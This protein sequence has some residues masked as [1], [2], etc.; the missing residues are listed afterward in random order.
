MELKYTIYTYIY[1]GKFIFLRDVIIA[2]HLSIKRKQ[3]TETIYSVSTHVVIVIIYT[4]RPV[5]FLL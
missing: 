3:L 5:M 4:G 1:K 2:G